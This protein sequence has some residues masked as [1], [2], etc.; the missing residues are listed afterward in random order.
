LRT[1]AG[2]D[3]ELRVQLGDRDAVF[4]AVCG[5]NLTALP[6]N[7]RHGYSAMISCKHKGTP[8]WGK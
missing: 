1:E 6:G 4:C 8:P 2:T 7:G 5:S 3:V